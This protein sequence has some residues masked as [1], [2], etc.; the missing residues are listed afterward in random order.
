M[1]PI[2]L[3]GKMQLKETKWLGSELAEEGLSL[4]LSH[5]NAHMHNYQLHG[6]AEKQHVKEQLGKRENKE[7]GRKRGSM[8]G[9]ESQDCRPSTTYVWNGS[10]ILK[11]SE[12]TVGAYKHGV[13]K[14]ILGFRSLTWEFNS[15]I[16]LCQVW[17][18]KGVGESYKNRREKITLWPL[19]P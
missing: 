10:P 9:P 3:V 6:L 11:A 12:V 8:S 7:G 2:F 16:P 18:R 5:S 4:G 13:Y 17:E 14:Y 19:T 15:L 1:S